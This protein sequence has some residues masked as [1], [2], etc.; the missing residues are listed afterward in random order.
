MYTIKIIKG[1]YKRNYKTV[2]LMFLLLFTIVLIG[3]ILNSKLVANVNIPSTD[4]VIFQEEPYTYNN[5]DI[6]SQKQIYAMNDSTFIKEY[7]L[8]GDIRF[9]MG[10]DQVLTPHSK[11]VFEDI[12]NVSDKE[13]LIVVPN[14]YD[15]SMIYNAP[16]YSLGVRQLIVGKLPRADTQIAINEVLA[17]AYAQTLNLSSINQLIGESIEVIINDEE[18]VFKI[19]G[20]YSGDFTAIITPNQFLNFSNDYKLKENTLITFL[21]KQ[22]KKQFIDDNNLT[23]DDYIDSRYNTTNYKLMITIVCDLLSVT[24]FILSNINLVSD[25][26]ILRFYYPNSAL[27]LYGIQP[28]FISVVALFLGKMIGNILI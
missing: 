8:I 2:I 13:Q 3:N 27:L 1:F 7:A 10:I 19:S 23:P 22:E 17:Q 9:D 21:S 20:V 18:K 12:T 16:N 24:I 28:V 6:I 15:E 26:Q 25:L 11:T 5:D 14:T 4:L